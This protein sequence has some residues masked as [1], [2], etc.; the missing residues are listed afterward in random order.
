MP[1]LHPIVSSFTSGE[2]SPKLKGRV[3]LAKYFMAC[4]TLENYIVMPQGGVTRRPGLRYVAEVKD[5]TK[6]TI[7]IPFE[8]S[9]A[10]AYMLEVGDQYIRFYKNGAR[11]EVAGVPVEVSTPYLSTDLRTLS[12]RLNR[13][14]SAD[15][16][17]FAHANYAPRKLERYSDT[18]WKLRTITFI[19]S[20]SYEY[21]MRTNVNVGGLGVNTTIT[22][23]A[24]SGTGI[25]FTAGAAA[26]LAS[27]VGRDIKIIGGANAGARATITIFT[28]TTHVTADIT[29][30]F[31]DLTANAAGNWIITASPKSAATPSQKSPAG[32]AATVT[33]AADGWRDPDDCHKFVVLNGGS[34]ELTGFTSTTVA[35]G[36]IRGELN[37]TTAA[38]SGAWSLEESSWSSPNGYP[39]AVC[40]DGAGRLVWAGT[41]A[42]PDSVWESKTEDFENYGLGILDD[43]AVSITL[44]DNKVNAVRWI[45]PI[46][47]LMIGT[48]GGEF[49]MT[50]GTAG[51]ITPSNVQVTSRAAYGSST[52]SPVRIGNVIIFVTRSGRRV[53]ELTFD[54]YT[55]TYTAPDLLQLAEHLTAPLTN[56]GAPPTITDIAYQKEPRDPDSRIWAVRSDGTLLCCTYLRA[57]NVI[58][59]S[60]QTTCGTFE[61]I[62]CIPHPNGDRDQAWTITN[63]TVNG[64]T[65][66]FVEIFDDCAHYYGTINT[67]AAWTC[68]SATAITSITVGHMPNATVQVVGDGAVFPDVTLDASGAGTISYAAKKIEVGLGYVSTLTTMP[69]EVAGGDGTSQGK[70][71][72]WAEILIRFFQTV[73][74]AVSASGRDV[75]ELSFRAS[76]DLMD[77]PPPLFTGDRRKENLGWGDGAITIQQTQPLPNTVLMISGILDLGGG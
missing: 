60:R 53:R 43:D 69:P 67:D 29:V 42:Q 70:K 13:T 68:D 22:P 51:P 58:A 47:N 76:G 23:A 17:Y 37:A 19:P 46:R 77:A 26:F 3:D 11:I 71:R 65:K 48:T 52:V 9:T 31:A 33:L 16:L 72:R 21:G 66:R 15:V 18:I 50:G 7:L 4:Q 34:I 74:A 39:S 8:F 5:S 20:P 49:E 12:V 62:A 40:F 64:A 28:D 35:N 45:Q 25:V 38:P 73:G 30:N 44:S 75:D 57:E 14:Q 36:T 41:I 24:T 56:G 1:R 2:W 27:D 6:T 32:L 61:A 10:Q 54:F 63:R 55:D 59:W